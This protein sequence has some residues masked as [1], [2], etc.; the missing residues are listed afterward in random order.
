MGCCGAVW[1]RLPNQHP[2]VFTP[3]HWAMGAPRPHGI[4]TTSGSCRIQKSCTPLSSRGQGGCVQEAPPC[5]GM[6]L[7]ARRAA[8]VLFLL[9]VASFTWNSR[10]AAGGPAELRGSARTFS[11]VGQYH[12]AFTGGCGNSCAGSAKGEKSF[13]NCMRISEFIHWVAFAFHP[14]PEPCAHCWHS[15]PI[16]YNIPGLHKPL[17]A[18]GVRGHW[19]ARPV[20]WRVTCEGLMLS[21]DPAPRSCESPAVFS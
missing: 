11:T 15:L 4:A 16:P 7:R 17:P 1:S 5:L 8:T 3:S 12:G 19:T 9:L 21:A 13:T 14:P 18:S 6:E 10:A 20:T 2:L